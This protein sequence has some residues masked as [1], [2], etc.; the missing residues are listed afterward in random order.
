MTSEK[1]HLSRIVML[2]APLLL[3]VENRTGLVHSRPARVRV[4][5]ERNPELFQETVHPVPHSCRGFS[6]P[7]HPP[8]ALEYHQPVRNGVKDLQIMV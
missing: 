8:D 5:P 2:P 3:P 7:P 4:P 6:Q 1:T